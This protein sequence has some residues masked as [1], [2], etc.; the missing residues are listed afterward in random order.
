MSGYLRKPDDQHRGEQRAEAKARLLM[1][2]IWVIYAGAG[3][4]TLAFYLSRAWP[5]C[6]GF[7]CELT[8]L[9][10]LIWA[11]LWPFYWMFYSNGIF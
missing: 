6:S 1:G 2:T 7:G 3:L 4:L 5:Q 10:A 11:G 8:L 9:K